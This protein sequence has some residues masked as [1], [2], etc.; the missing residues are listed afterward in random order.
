[1]SVLEASS[2][3][4]LTGIPVEDAFTH[5]SG[6]HVGGIINNARTYEFIDP[7]RLGIQRAF[8]EIKIMIDGMK[9]RFDKP[10]PIGSVGGIHR[11]SK[12]GK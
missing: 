5:K 9:R 10:V 11:N 8:N 3:V 12:Y 1:M 4:N 7:A 2:A 6:V